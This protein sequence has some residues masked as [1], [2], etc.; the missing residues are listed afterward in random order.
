MADHGEHGDGVDYGQDS[1][2]SEHEQL[3]YQPYRGQRRAW[4]DEHSEDEAVPPGQEDG[5]EDQGQGQHRREQHEEGPE[6]GEPGRELRPSRHAGVLTPFPAGYPEEHDVTAFLGQVGQQDDSVP[7]DVRSHQ[8][9]RVFWQ[10]VI[11]LFEAVGIET[12]QGLS[13]YRH[14]HC[15]QLWTPLSPC[16]H[17]MAFSGY[18]QLRL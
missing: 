12:S 15:F 16:L 3:G 6:E 1:A 4:G 18:L 14:P 17:K 5:Q 13:D 10:D 2:E 7:M 8:T 11:H 9:Y